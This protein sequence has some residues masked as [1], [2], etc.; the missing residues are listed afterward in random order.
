MSAKEGRLILETRCPHCSASHIVSATVIGA[1]ASCPKCG[2]EHPVNPKAAS[3]TEGLLAAIL[4]E[5][6]EQSAI[7]RRIE[8][9]LFT[10]RLSFGVAFVVVL[11]FGLRISFK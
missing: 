11:V 3:A 7:L 5:Q 2:K 9:S 4:T 6:R 1:T 10:F 8:T